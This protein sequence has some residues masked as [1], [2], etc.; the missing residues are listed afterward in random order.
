[1]SK[2]RAGKAYTLN[3]TLTRKGMSFDVSS[4][5]WADPIVFST[6][7]DSWKDREENIDLDE[8]IE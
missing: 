5:D 2:V 3:I 4:E 6:G 1:M 8:E 7:I